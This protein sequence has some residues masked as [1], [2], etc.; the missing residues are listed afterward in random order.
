MRLQPPE[1]ELP[2]SNQGESSPLLS[3]DWGQGQRPESFGRLQSE[4]QISDPSRL[5]T[6]GCAIGGWD[7]LLVAF[8]L[9]CQDQALAIAFETRNMPPGACGALAVTFRVIR[10]GQNL[11]RDSNF[12]GSCL[13]SAPVGKAFSPASP[14]AGEMHTC[15]PNPLASP[16][17]LDSI[18]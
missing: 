11:D 9:Q 15:P 2:G 8:L 5:T 4:L 17:Q 14:D 18:S 7:A 10:S 12:L 16:I 3:G 13:V 1:F 6:D